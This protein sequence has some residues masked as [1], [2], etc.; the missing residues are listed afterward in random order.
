MRESIRF[1]EV[2]AAF[3]TEDEVPTSF[4]ARL[5]AALNGE[6][7]DEAAAIAPSDALFAGFAR[8]RHMLGPVVAEH[9]FTNRWHRVDDLRSRTGVV[10]DRHGP[11]EYVLDLDRKSYRITPRDD[12]AAPQPVVFSA[13][14][15][16]PIRTQPGRNILSYSQ[17]L[18]D[19]SEGSKHG[20]Q[21]MVWNAKTRIALTSSLPPCHDFRVE[22]DSLVE[23]ASNVGAAFGHRFVPHDVYGWDWYG[24]LMTRFVRSAL[25]EA[26]CA[27][28][29]HDEP[30]EPVT[31][32]RARTSEAGHFL[33]SERTVIDVMELP[34]RGVV[35]DHL[36]YVRD[37]ADVEFVDVRDDLPPL[38]GLRQD[39]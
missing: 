23:L 27:V 10:R 35:R 8:L 2:A 34:T 3:R 17:R 12:S 32:A 24:S 4:A 9:T 18:V 25:A 33:L 11:S 14:T 26:G 20:L 1:V 39:D 37:R 30:G 38:E 36:V 21:T 19:R 16:R 22:I 7:R 13:A 5:A 31:D 15:N 28:A 29:V 6:V